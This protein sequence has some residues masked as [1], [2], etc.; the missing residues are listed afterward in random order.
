MFLGG[1][2]ICE[3]KLCSQELQQVLKV[4]LRHYIMGRKPTLPGTTTSLP[5]EIP[6]LPTSHCKARAVEHTHPPPHSLITPVPSTAHTSPIHCSRHPHALLTPSPCSSQP[7]PLLTPWPISWDETRLNND[8]FLVG[9]E[10]VEI[11]S[12]NKWLEKSQHL[13]VLR[14]K[15]RGQKLFAWP[16]PA[17]CPPQVPRP[18]PLQQWQRKDLAQLH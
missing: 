7:Q 5:P 18:C 3:A 11:C 1:D 4:S 17:P 16:S 6:P 10:D 14:S 12:R 9:R 8:R 2:V 13:L 15:I